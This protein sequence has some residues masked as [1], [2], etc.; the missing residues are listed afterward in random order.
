MKT[1]KVLQTIDVMT[2][3]VVKEL[4]D[5]SEKIDGKANHSHVQTIAKH[6]MNLEQRVTDLEKEK[7]ENEPEWMINLRNHLDNLLNSSKSDFTKAI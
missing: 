6:L 7:W 2:E 4:N 1:K 3:S 5:M